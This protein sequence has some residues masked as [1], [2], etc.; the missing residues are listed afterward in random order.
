MRPT[1]AVLGAGGFIGNR[2]VETLHL[3]GEHRV[4]PV[5]RR[6]ASLALSARFSL[7]CRLADARDEAALI[8]AFSGCTY[9][10]HA[11][12]GPPDTVVGA[13]APVYRAA[14]ASGVRRL[15]YLSSASVH[16]Q[17][18]AEGTD[19]DSPLNARQSVAYNNA[20][21]AA[22]RILQDLRQGGAS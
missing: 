5:A 20:K 17:S 9:V 22:E 3:R 12:A 1:V 4:R 21:V 13:V 16:G 7:D 2:L 15:V 14:A 8:E 18:P 19:E 11:V 10:V 6:A